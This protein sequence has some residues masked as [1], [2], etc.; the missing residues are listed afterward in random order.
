MGNFVS[1]CNSEPGQNAV[2]VNLVEDSGGPKGGEAL[3]VQ[4]SVTQQTALKSETPPE[5]VVVEPEPA[6][7]LQEEPPP[8]VEEKPLAEPEKPP[9]EPVILVFS[10]AD[11]QKQDVRVDRRPLG[12]WYDQKV[13][14]KI[15][16]VAK[17]FAGAAAGVK[18]GWTLMSVNGEDVSQPSMSYAKVTEILDKH[19]KKLPQ[20]GGISTGTSVDLVFSG[21]DGDVTFMAVWRPLGVQF[22][23][24][25]P[26]CVEKTEAGSYGGLIGIRPGMIMKSVG[27]ADLSKCSSYEEAITTLRKQMEMLPELNGGARLQSQVSC[28]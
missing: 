25:I 3:V 23:K 10:A 16:Q 21:G 6:A 20:G 4:P 19:V 26:I 2:E 27:G 13:P 8:V 1:C 5:K 17:E 24:Q 28:R 15:G 14:L 12:L 18:E 11:G 9:A 7:A 22:I